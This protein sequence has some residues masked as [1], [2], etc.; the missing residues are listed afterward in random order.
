MKPRLLSV[1]VILSLCCL[2]GCG[3][4][5]ATTTNRATPTAIP[6]TPTLSPATVVPSPTPTTDRDPFQVNFL[7]HYQL[8]TCPTGS[9]PTNLCYTLQ[10]D[11]STSSLGKIS[12]AGTDILY[13]LPQ[14]ATCGPAERS[15]ALN[16]A[17]GNT[18]TIHATGT[19]CVPGY[20]VQFSFAVTGGTGK[21]RHASGGGTIDVGPARNN[22][23]TADEFW[24][25]TIRQS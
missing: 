8:I 22:P 12:F 15:G 19:Y 17:D 18:I 11:P 23:P 14:G 21:Y 16:V 4:S 7:Q 24:S 2:I 13:V 3:A 5:P 6:A 1:L 10:D 20:P 9:K 25:G